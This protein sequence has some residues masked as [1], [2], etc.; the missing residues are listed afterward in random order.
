M[1]YEVTVKALEEGK[2][3][4]E[5]EVKAALWE[6]IKEIDSKNK[7]KI[8]IKWEHAR[9]NILDTWRSMSLLEKIMLYSMISS[10]GTVA[11]KLLTECRLQKRE[12]RLQKA[13][14]KIYKI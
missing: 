10:L 4:S 7:T 1:K 11:L 9:H 5:A 14:F 6:C 8:G 13:A 2:E 12:H 3:V